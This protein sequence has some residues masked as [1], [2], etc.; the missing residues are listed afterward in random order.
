MD[1]GC[2]RFKKSVAVDEA[3][4]GAFVERA[5]DLSRQGKDIGC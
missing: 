5:A 3:K 2:I 1:T 4:I